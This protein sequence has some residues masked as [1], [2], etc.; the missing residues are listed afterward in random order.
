[1]DY[2]SGN[3]EWH[4]KENYCICTVYNIKETALVGLG[5]ARKHQFELNEGGVSSNKKFVLLGISTI[6]V[7]MIIEL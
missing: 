7:Q 1:L 6:Q 2:T 4:L 3:F 5:I